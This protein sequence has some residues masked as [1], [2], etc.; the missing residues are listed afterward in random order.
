M[1]KRKRVLKMLYIVF[2]ITFTVVLSSCSESNTVM[3]EY[4]TKKEI[5]NEKLGQVQSEVEQK[6]CSLCGDE[7]VINYPDVYLGNNSIGL[8]NLNSWEVYDLELDIG[9]EYSEDCTSI[10]IVNIGNHSTTIQ[11]IKPSA[12]NMCQINLS[13]LESARVEDMNKMLCESCIREIVEEADY[14]LAFIDFTTKELKPIQKNVV[15]T[16]ISDYYIHLD[17]IKENGSI[18]AIEILIFYLPKKEKS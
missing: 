16:T 17:P 13:N 6:N 1:I 7:P 9:E 11:L 2:L 4:K 14:D 3:T 18:S 5:K 10:Q 15:G 12:Y 8:I